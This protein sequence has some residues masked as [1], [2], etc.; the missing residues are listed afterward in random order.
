MGASFYTQFRTGLCGYPEL[1]TQMMWRR[2]T[3]QLEHEPPGI[4]PGRE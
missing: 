2:N 1:L 3:I 4:S